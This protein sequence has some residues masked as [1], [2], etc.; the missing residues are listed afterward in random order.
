MHTYARDQGLQTQEWV[1]QVGKGI[2]NMF[3][4]CQTLAL[5]HVGNVVSWE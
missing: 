1:E 2:H 3:Q 5:G 4:H